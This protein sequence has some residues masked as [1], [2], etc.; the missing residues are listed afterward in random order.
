MKEIC[1]QIEDK[2]EEMNQRAAQYGLLDPNVLAISEELDALIN[3]YF[4]EKNSRSND[5]LYYI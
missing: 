1:Q 2:R 5:Y 3:Y 4:Y